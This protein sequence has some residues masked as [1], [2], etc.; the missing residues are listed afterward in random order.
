MKIPAWTRAISS[1]EAVNRRVAVSYW[2]T[3]T[4]HA[5]HEA[6][7]ARA[8]AATLDKELVQ[9]FVELDTLDKE[10]R[11]RCAACAGDARMPA[12]DMMPSLCAECAEEVLER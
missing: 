2:L 12:S 10:T 7:A 4:R 11:R 3:A 5:L 8:L 6:M 9:L 1:C